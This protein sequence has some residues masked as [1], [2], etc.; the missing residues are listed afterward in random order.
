VR[1]LKIYSLYVLT[2]CL[3]IYGLI[4]IVSKYVNDKE[5]SIFR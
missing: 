1:E 3:D 4:S 5:Y 2:V